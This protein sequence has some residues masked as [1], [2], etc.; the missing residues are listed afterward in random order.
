M[1]GPLGSANPRNPQRAPEPRSTVQRATTTPSRRSWAWTFFARRRQSS[2]VDAV[3]LDQQ[4]LVAQCSLRGWS[5]LERVVRA[6]RDLRARCGQRPT[7]RLD[8][9]LMLVLVDVF[10]INA[11]GGRAPPRKKPR[12]TSGSGVRPA[13]L[14]HFLLQLD[15]AL[16][17]AGR[18][19]G[20]VPLVDLGLH[21]P[22]PQ[23][24][25]ID[26]QLLAHTANVPDLVDGSRR[27]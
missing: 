7:D 18:G 10:P 21:N 20:T 16:G 25:R 4:F 11:V 1:R 8:A 3:D 26:P 22:V 2:P 19:P 5:G 14:T 6:R 23:S 15:Q 12:P 13:Q 9:E 24:L 27:D 17:L